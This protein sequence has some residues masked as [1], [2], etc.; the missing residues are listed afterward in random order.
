MST[1]NNAI[2]GAINGAITNALGSSSAGASR[3]V[4]DNIISEVNLTDI[5]V[6]T[7]SSGVVV[8]QVSAVEGIN[9]DNIGSPEYDSTMFGGAGGTIFK[10]QA[11]GL[12]HLTTFSPTST[13]TIIV[14]IHTP[15]YNVF[16]D[17][18]SFALADNLGNTLARF[19]HSGAGDIFYYQNE[20]GTYQALQE[21]GADGD[22]IIVL[23]FNDATSCDFFFDSTT[24]T[25][26]FDPKVNYNTQTKIRLGTRAA[27]SA[28]ANSGYGYFLHV[29]DAMTDSEIANY[30]NY[31]ASVVN[32]TVS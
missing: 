32:V 6:Y 20:A 16:G 10:T 28:V 22:H 15:T 4:I 12:R 8:D 29:G 31:I 27:T 26:T 7:F 14:A 23:R 19:T 9:L 2:N 1:I 5:S 11:Q 25:G 13:Q 21:N 3:P 17:L 24:K 30:V 18:F